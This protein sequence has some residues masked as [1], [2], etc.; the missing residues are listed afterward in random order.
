MVTVGAQN[1]RLSYAVTGDAGL[2]S[3]MIK[4]RLAVRH[5]FSSYSANGLRMNISSILNDW[6]AADDLSGTV[7]VDFMEISSE[8]QVC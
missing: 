5:A 6:R 7:E 4:A 1:F 8:D 3:E 2:S